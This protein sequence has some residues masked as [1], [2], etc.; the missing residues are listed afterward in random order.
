MFLWVENAPDLSTL[1]EGVVPP[2]MKTFVDSIV[3]AQQRSE[4]NDV[5]FSE[6]MPPCMPAPWHSM[7]EDVAKVHV[8]ALAQCVQTYPCN[9]HCKPGGQHTKS[10]IECPRPLSN[11][12]TMRKFIRNRQTKLVVSPAR[13]LSRVNA[14][15]PS[16]QSCWGANM[17]VPIYSTSTRRPCTQHLI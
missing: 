14:Y 7:E 5:D 13:A 17:D 15:N 2:E 10:L 6:D 3:C 8:A 11:E 16:F 1:G 4:M 12:N 9:A